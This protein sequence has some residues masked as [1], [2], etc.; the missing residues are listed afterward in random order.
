MCGL[1]AI[2]NA[3]NLCYSPFSTFF[4]CVCVVRTNFIVI[5][6]FRVPQLHSNDSIGCESLNG[7][8][9]VDISKNEITLFLMCI[10]RFH[11]ILYWCSVHT[12]GENDYFRKL[13]NIVNIYIQI[14]HITHTHITY[15]IIRFYQFKF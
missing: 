1:S 15:R 3:H 7:W 14:H 4:Q 13:L 6:F 11:A 5:W 8:L 9:N 10:C 2:Y 12:V